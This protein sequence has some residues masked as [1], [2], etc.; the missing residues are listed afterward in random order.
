MSG[1]GAIPCLRCN[2]NVLD[3]SP[4]P[5]FDEPGRG[6]VCY[7]CLLAAER[8][9][10]ERAET[11]VSDLEAIVAAGVA[12]TKFMADDLARAEHQRDAALAR[13]DVL[14]EQG[15][16]IARERDAYD[17]IH[18]ARNDALTEALDLLSQRTGERDAL[19]AVVEAV[20]AYRR[21]IGPRLEWGAAMDAGEVGALADATAALDN[22][23]AALPGPAGGDTVNPLPW[24]TRLQDWLEAGFV[25]LA[26]LQLLGVALAVRGWRRLR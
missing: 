5:P 11:K 13:C 1:F 26:G 14:A 19:R 7:L 25:L 22:A 15:E 23:L 2:R 17:N 16:A 12:A 9:R 21:A 20:R 4:G 10:A 6:Y 8:A 24:R 18:K 3:D